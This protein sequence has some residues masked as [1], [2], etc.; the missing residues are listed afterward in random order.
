MLGLSGQ[1]LLGL[2]GRTLP[3][4]SG[5]ILL[6]LSGQTLPGL[7]GGLS[8]QYSVSQPAGLGLAGRGLPGAWERREGVE[9]VGVWAEGRAG[10]SGAM[11]AAVRQR[12]QA[13]W[14]A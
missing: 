14:L 8:G 5:Q 13:A 6:G 11:R 9:D 4:Q 1:A 2:S 7:S 10:V 3:D 12:L